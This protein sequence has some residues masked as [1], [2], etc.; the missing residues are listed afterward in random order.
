MFSKEIMRKIPNTHEMREFFKWN[1]GVRLAR[2]M[3]ATDPFSFFRRGA[4]GSYQEGRIT[5]FNQGLYEQSTVQKQ[6]LG[7]KRELDDGRTYRYC[8]ATAANIAAGLCIS[9]V[10]TPVDATIAAADAAIGLAGVREV[11]LTIAGATTNLYA[12]GLLVIKAG[13]DIGKMY[14]VRGNAATN[15]PATGRANFSLYEPIQTL[16]VA[17][18]TTVAAHQNPYKDLLINPA[19]ANEAA[20]TQETVMGLTTQII[21]ASCYFWAQT[22]GLASMVLDVAAA[23]G[24]EANEGIIVPGIVTGTGTVRADTAPLGMQILGNTLE[25]ADLTNTEANLVFLLI[26]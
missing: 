6:R 10:Q 14:K 25:S 13:A 5:M 20:T 21:T 18:N 15:I 2:K 3:G 4:V 26:E 17:A 12:D 8:L 24:A 22:H 1:L 9:K 7:T 19:V 23:A 16:W 11:T